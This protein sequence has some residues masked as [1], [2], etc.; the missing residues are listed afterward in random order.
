MA[1]GPEV[2]VIVGAYRR[3]EYLR[4][5]VR[6]LL[7]QTLARARFEI[8]VIKNFREET[9]DR[10]LAQAG[11]VVLFDE[12]PRIGRWLRHAIRV[13]RAPIITFCDD[14]DEFE[15]DRL[16]RLLEV[17]A[18]H[19]DLGLYRNRVRVIDRAGRP[20]PPALWRPHETDAGFDTLGPVYRSAG[21]KADLLNLATQTT[22]STFATSTM[23]LRRELLDGEL[24]DE[25][26]RT[27]L[28][29]LFLFLTGVVAPYGVYLDD[30]RLTRYRFYP[31]NVTHTVR[32]LGHAMESERDM[33]EVAER[34]GHHDFAQWLTARAVNHER[35]FLGGTLVEEVGAGVGRRSA[36]R[37]TAGYLRFLAGHPEERA[38]TLD[39]WA[40]SLYGLSYLAIPPLARRVAKARLTARGVH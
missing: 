36:A 38:W 32:W 20:I 3:Q 25:F 27:Q 30:R 9:I 14:D 15:P 31:G 4:L 28:E 34:H 26:E 35:L 7:S 19:C 8:V 22:Q 37:Q 13:S 33:A 6:S 2:S 1:D 23:A 10:E 11:A 5:A 18:A 24:G 21:E 17:F 39:V 29:D 40:A 12:E 16:E